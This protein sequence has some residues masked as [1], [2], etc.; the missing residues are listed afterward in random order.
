MSEWQEEEVLGKAYDGRLMRRFLRYV[1]PHAGLVIFSFVIILLRIAADLVGPLIV[2]GA[3]DGPVASRDARGLLFYTVLFVGSIAAVS[4]LSYL[5]TLLTNL[6]G[7]RV[8]YDVRV[9]L[10]RHLQRL[11]QAFYDRTPVGRLMTRTTNDVE[12]LNELVTS[13]LVE[14][15]ADVLLLAGVVVLMFVTSWRMALVTM[16]MS[17]LI[18]AGALVFRR[19]ARERYREMRTRIAKVNAWLNETVNGARTIQVFSREKASAAKWERLNDEFRESALGAVLVYSFFFP[20]VELVSSI[21]L[22]ILLWYGGTSIGGGTMT[23][24]AFVA[25]WYYAQKFYQPV[26]D[27]AEKY[28][29]LQA[30]MASSER[31]FKLMDE[32]VVLQPGTRPAGELRGAIAFDDVRFSY[33]GK[34]P[35]LDGVSFAVEPGQTLA[36]VGLTGAGKSTIINLLLRLYDV[37]GGRVTIDGRDVREYDPQSLR[38]KTALVLQDVF[39]FSGSVAENIRLG[40]DIPRERVEQAARTANAMKFIER[41]PKKLETEVGERGLALSTGERQLLSFARALAADPRILIL[42][43]ATSSVDSE[44]EALIQDALAKLLKGRTSIVIA[45]RLSTIRNADR[46]LVLHH[47]KI[48]EAGSHEELLAKDGLYAKLHRLQF[49]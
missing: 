16:A 6:C 30:A 5:E 49:A 4:L 48:A 47:G 12:N 35:V 14:F 44:S 36:V 25:F 37:T 29:V 34:T 22:A 10:F 41:L 33:D 9:G 46:I 45:H 32:P 3:V 24:G 1:R 31:I 27:L 23:F 19:F 2:K 21:G 17:P 28:N 8:I 38:H 40:A 26:R 43:E 15:V 13:G 42:D 11:P 20:A 7:Q 39:L 18:V